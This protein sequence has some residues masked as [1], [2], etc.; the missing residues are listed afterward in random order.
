MCSECGWDQD[1]ELPEDQTDLPEM[2]DESDE[3]DES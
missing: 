1:Y 2:E 3:S